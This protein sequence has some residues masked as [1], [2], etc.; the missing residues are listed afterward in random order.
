MSE[1]GTIALKQWS[2]VDSLQ[3]TCHVD[4]FSFYNT[5]VTCLLAK[6]QCDHVFRIYCV[7]H[8][9]DLETDTILEN[10]A[11]EFQQMLLESEETVPF[12]KDISNVVGG[13]SVH[14]M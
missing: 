1:T 12:R 13:D 8:Q 4:W 11:F 3:K 2:V 9:Q 14:N 5:S 7:L 10:W 6:T